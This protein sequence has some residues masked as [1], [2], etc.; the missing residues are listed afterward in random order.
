MKKVF[1]L[2]LALALVLTMSSMLCFAS[3]EES[4]T[5]ATVVK[6]AADPWFIRMEEG[7]QKFAEE[8]GYVCYQK[9]PSTTDSAQ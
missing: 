5:I 3:A 1:S 4:F 9:G 7:V 2:V 6:D 8:S